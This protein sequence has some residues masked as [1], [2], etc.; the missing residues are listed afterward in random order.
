MP[1]RFQIGQQVI[2]SPVPEKV[3]TPR[4]SALEPYAGL[5]GRVA[6]YHWLNLGRG[7]EPVYIYT[8]QIG[9]ERQ[10]VVLHE[11]ELMALVA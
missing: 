7:D 6:D 5:V 3:P 1:P 9:D 8:V 2:V 10:K 11:D 4:D